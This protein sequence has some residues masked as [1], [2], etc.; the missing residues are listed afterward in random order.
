QMLNTQN[1]ENAEVRAKIK[2][3]LGAVNRSSGSSGWLKDLFMQKYDAYDA[4]VNYEAVLIET[5]QE[6]VKQGREPLYAIYPSDGLAIADSPLAYVDHKDAA[7]AELVHKLQSYLLSQNVQ[8]QI[9]QLGRR[10]GPVGEPM[11]S[12]DRSVFNPEW[13]IQTDKLLPQIRFP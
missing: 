5:N 2:R 3:I 1:L 10:T 9:T 8:K 13:G 12:P 11:Q 7:K 6:L 4:M